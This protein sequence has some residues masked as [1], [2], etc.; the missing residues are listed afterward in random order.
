MA[1]ALLCGFGEGRTVECANRECQHRR[2]LLQRWKHGSEGVFIQGRWYCCVECSE[3]A[4]TSLV[5]ELVHIPDGSP[6]RAHR[7][8]LGLLL[9][10]RGVITEDQLKEALRI[11]REGNGERVGQCLLRQGAI[12]HEDIAQG[13]AAQWGCAVFPIQRDPSYLECAAR[14]PL[15]LLEARRMLPVHYL[16]SSRLLYVAFSDQLDRTSLY[17]VER[18][19]GDRTVAC[20][21]TESGMREAFEELRGMERPLE[22]V[23]ELRSPRAIAETILEHWRET[24]AQEMKFARP[25][26]YLWVRLLAAAETRDLLFRLHGPS[27]A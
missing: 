10:G 19:L 15:S 11:Q 7:V 21:I 17:A 3:P 18:L 25:A 26:G 27:P 13:L 12:T 24:G 9:L 1:G 20:V 23:S 22:I 5:E 4:L 2:T 8:P 16:S 14:L 6:Q